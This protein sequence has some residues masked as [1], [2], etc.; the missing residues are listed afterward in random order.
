ML[1]YRL[2]TVLR[3]RVRMP[4]GRRERDSTRE[5]HPLEMSPFEREKKI[6]FIFFS[7]FFLL[8]FS[9]LK[10]CSISLQVDSQPQHRRQQHP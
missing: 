10:Q 6:I 7:F 3:I 1:R 4:L 9:F 5:A 2:S 8:F